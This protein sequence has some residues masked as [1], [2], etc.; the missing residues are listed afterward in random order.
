MATMAVTAVSAALI[1]YESCRSRVHPAGAWTKACV[2][3]P[4]KSIVIDSGQFFS[5]VM[6][7]DESLD[8]LDVSFVH[9]SVLPFH[10]VCIVQFVREKDMPACTDLRGSAH[11]RRSSQV[12]VYTVC[13]SMA[14][15]G[16]PCRPGKRRNSCG[17][18][19]FSLEGT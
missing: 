3:G 9:D 1:L 8:C 16:C 11:G 4:V 5:R 10:L 15:C 2:E 19:F 14:L 7:I 18:N 6:L 13:T 12:P 17:K